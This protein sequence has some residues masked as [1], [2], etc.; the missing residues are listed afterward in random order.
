MKLKKIKKPNREAKTL[1]LHLRVPPQVNQKVAEDAKKYGI[2]K[3]SYI[4]HLIMNAEF[5]E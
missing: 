4:E 3:S 1:N 5:Y 2:S